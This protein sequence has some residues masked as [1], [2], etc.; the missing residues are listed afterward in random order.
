MGRRLPILG[1]G[2]APEGV[3]RHSQE[4]RGS[5]KK[6]QKLFFEKKAHFILHDCKSFATFV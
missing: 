1:A 5:E 6:A 4:D 3:A 2:H